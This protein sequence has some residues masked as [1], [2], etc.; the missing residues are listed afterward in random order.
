[1][2]TSLALC[3]FVGVSYYFVAFCENYYL[4]EINTWVDKLNLWNKDPADKYIES[5]YWALASNHLNF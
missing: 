5:Y 4:G 1:M 3:H 2:C